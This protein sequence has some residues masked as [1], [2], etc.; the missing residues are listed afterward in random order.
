MKGGRKSRGAH[1]LVTLLQWTW[2]KRTR[3]GDCCGMP[4]VPYKRSL[5]GSFW[6]DSTGERLLE[7]QRLTAPKHTIELPD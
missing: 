4:R 5:K 7:L 2:R 1:N 3:A 6:V